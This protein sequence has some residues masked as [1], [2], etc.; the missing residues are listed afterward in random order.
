MLPSAWEPLAVVVGVPIIII[1]SA[2]KFPSPLGLCFLNP[3]EESLCSLATL[4]LACLGSEKTH[5]SSNFACRGLCI[6]AQ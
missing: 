4:A 5:L 1:H 3:A 6:G 2:L